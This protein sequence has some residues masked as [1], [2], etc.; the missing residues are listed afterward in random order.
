MGEINERRI[1]AMARKIWFIVAILG[2][3]SQSWAAGGTCPSSAN[4]LNTTNPTGSLV[5]LA[6]LGISSCYFVAANGSD[7]NNGTSEST[8]WLHAPGMQSCTGNC[9]SNS[10]GAGIGYIFR[11]GDTWHFGNTSAAPYSGGSWFW[12]WYGSSGSPIYIGVDPSWY[13]GASWARPILTADNPTSTGPVSS[14]QYLVAENTI[15]ERK[16]NIIW[17]SSRYSIFDNFEFT[18]LCWNADSGDNSYIHYTGYNSGSNNLGWYIQNNYVHGWTYTSAGGQSGGSG[19]AGYNQAYGAILRFNVI[20]GSDS[21]YHALQA[22]GQGSDGYDLEYNVTR[23]TGGTV[24]FDDC[25]I[26]HDNLWEYESNV[27]DGSAHTDVYFCYGEYAGGSSNPNLFYNNI[28]RYIGTLDSATISYNFTLDTPSSQTDYVFNNVFHDFYGG[29]AGW[30]YNAMCDPGGGCGPTI[31]WNNTA[32][33]ALPNYSCCIWNAP[34]NTITNDVN[35]H[36]I[37]AGTGESAVFG[38]N[39]QTGLTQTTPLYQT[40]SVATGQGYTSNNDF[41]PTSS[42]GVTV[43][44][45][46]TNET[47]NY[48]ADSVLHNATAE[49]ACVQGMTGISYNSTTHAVVCPAFTAVSRP[50]SGAWNVGAYQFVSGATPAPPASVTAT[51]H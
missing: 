10:P 45:S 41:S 47:T 5:T 30:N 50:S 11:G 40:Y 32:E 21:D 18:G 37:A 9:A 49:A 33:A 44:T 19:I 4:Y 1:T 2:L 28:F 17:I 24:V 16:N 27:T 36:Y 26:A 43:T 7:S 13:S 51:P 23:Y 15:T 12:S 42:S 29:T 48:C 14:C 6:S 39:G 34:A 31:M 22:W 8:P 20:D 38:T 25:H 46:G 3:T 35:S